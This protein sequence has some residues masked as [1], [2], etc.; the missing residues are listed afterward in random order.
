MVEGKAVQG[1]VRFPGGGYKAVMALPSPSNL[2]VSAC[3]AQHSR[4]PP[5]PSSSE[6]LVC[7][8][9]SDRIRLLFSRRIREIQRS[10]GSGGRRRP[11][12]GRGF[13]ESR[14]PD[15]YGE[16]A[17]LRS[18]R[19]RR[20]TNSG[21]GKGDPNTFATLTSTSSVPRTVTVRERN[22]FQPW[23]RVVYRCWKERLGISA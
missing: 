14:R 12:R 1:S 16:G 5:Q 19:S 3:P 18:S 9:L 10:F 22:F 20:A 17:Q 4:P 13:L 23:K 7:W 21:A 8:T 2:I 11:S 6:C 15:G